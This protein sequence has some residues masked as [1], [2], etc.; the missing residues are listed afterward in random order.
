MAGPL[1]AHDPTA[2]GLDGFVPTPVEAVM[3][4]PLKDRSESFAQTITF[5]AGKPVRARLRYAP[6]PAPAGCGTNSGL[7]LARL[8]GPRVRKNGES[9][10][11]P[12]L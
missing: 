1:P 3:E 11:A 12:D 10:R 2:T 9:R 6:Q 5:G 8:D 7:P 4:L